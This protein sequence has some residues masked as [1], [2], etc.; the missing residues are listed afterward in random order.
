[1]I[2]KQL[3]KFKLFLMFIEFV[4]LKINLMFIFDLNL[5]YWE[6]HFQCRYPGSSTTPYN[7]YNRTCS[8][9]ERLSADN[10]DFEDQLQF[11]SDA[12]M[13]F[14]YALR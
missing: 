8:T 12:V 6:D 1:M 9:E 5:E 2:Y 11:V 14:G 7:N 10:M 13:A 3:I 4:Q